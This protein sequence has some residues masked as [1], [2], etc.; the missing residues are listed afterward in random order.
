MDCGRPWSD[1]VEIAMF[2]AA[3]RAE[4]DRDTTWYCVRCRH[5]VR[6][7]VHDHISFGGCS[8][9]SS[10]LWVT[11]IGSLRPMIHVRPLHL[12]G[13]GTAEPAYDDD[14]DENYEFRL[15]NPSPCLLC[16]VQRWQ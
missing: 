8:R 1:G 10:G 6:R 12:L 5:A 2:T 13:S 15:V 4:A 9:I 14:I 3:R 16:Q 11:L 7:Y